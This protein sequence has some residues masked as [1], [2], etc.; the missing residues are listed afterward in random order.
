MLIPLASMTATWN[1]GAGKFSVLAGQDVGIV[2]TLFAESL[3]WVAKPLFWQAGHLW[4][5]SPQFRGTWANTFGDYGVSAAVAVL[6]PA[7]TQA[8]T[9]VPAVTPNP[10]FGAGNQSRMPNIEARL[11]GTAKFAPDVTA[12]VGLGYHMNTRRLAYGT[13]NQLDVDGSL[14]GVDVD[15]GL[16]K[17]AQVKGEYYTGEGSDDTYNAI[18][19]STYG[20]GLNVKALKSSGYWAQLI[21]KPVAWA[22]IT[23]GIGHGEADKATSATN[24]RIAN[25]Q[26]A[27]G[28][29]F[30]AGKA[31]RFGVEYTQVTSEYLTT[32]GGAATTKQDATQIGVSSMLRF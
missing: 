22:W 1:T 25:D 8:G 27:G 31:W 18:G 28:L 17:F 5:R 29:I 7:T 15:L 12:A 9:A 24:A 6:S 23:V 20:T 4:R 10:D 11:A 30:N 13:A 21:A 2:N 3:A 26:L 14:L 19:A 32:A 16:T